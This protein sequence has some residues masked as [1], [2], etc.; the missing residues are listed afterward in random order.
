M[1]IS[2]SQRP[3]S[4]ECEIHVEVRITRGGELLGQGIL[5]LE[6]TEEPILFKSAGLALQ[7][8]IYEVLRGI[9]PQTDPDNSGD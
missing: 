8:G 5:T 6:P 1:P 7:A 2:F 3:L 4:P 9:W